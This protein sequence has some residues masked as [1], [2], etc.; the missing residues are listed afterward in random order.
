[1]V[2]QRPKANLDVHVHDI[3]LM[4]EAQS[5]EHLPHQPEHLC[6]VKALIIHDVLEQFAASRAKTYK[7]NTTCNTHNFTVLY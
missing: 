6:L 7:T 3:P 1:M 5:I 2:Q 4:Q